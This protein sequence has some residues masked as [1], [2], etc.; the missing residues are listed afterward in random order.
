MID[1]TTV[2]LKSLELRAAHAKRVQEIV[3]NANN[4]IRREEEK[5]TAQLARVH[6]HENPKPGP[7]VSAL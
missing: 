1:A 3:A 7:K 4:E 6:E 2:N 5:L